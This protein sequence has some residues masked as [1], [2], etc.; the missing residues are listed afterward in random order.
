MY[1]YNQI[2]KISLGASWGRRGSEDS[3]VGISSV[4]EG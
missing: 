4:F 3:E 1:I 2:A